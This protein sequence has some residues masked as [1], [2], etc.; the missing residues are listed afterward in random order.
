M[1]E[2]FQNNRKIRTQI[3][4]EILLEKIWLGIRDGNI[5]FEDS[6]DFDISEIESIYEHQEDN[7]NYSVETL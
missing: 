7:E 2:S 1:N 3:T 4:D 5:A 6:L